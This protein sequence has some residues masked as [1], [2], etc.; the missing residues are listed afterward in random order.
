ME[1]ASQF[2]LFLD[3]DGVLHPQGGGAAGPRFSQ[4]PLLEAW[5]REPDHARVGIVI[6]STWREA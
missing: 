1:T 5:L 3:F 2:V 6:S 4:L